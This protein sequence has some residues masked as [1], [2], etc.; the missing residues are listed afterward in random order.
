MPEIT[1]KLSEAIRLGGMTGPQAFGYYGAGVTAAMLGSAPLP[2]GTP[3]CA[4]GGAYIAAGVKATLSRSLSQ[5]LSI[6]VDI[7]IPEHWEPILSL[8]V[9]CPSCKGSSRCRSMIIHLNDFHH[10]TRNQISDFIETVEAFS[11]SAVSLEEG[12]QHCEQSQLVT[13]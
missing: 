12:L 13:K 6:A 7:R 8:M 2:E 3:T 11:P 5:G 9:K 4:L 1:M 10:W